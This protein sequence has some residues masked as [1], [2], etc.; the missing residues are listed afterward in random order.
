MEEG[1]KRRR[2]PGCAEHLPPGEQVHLAGQDGEGQAAKDGGSQSFRTLDLCGSLQFASDRQRPDADQPEGALGGSI[3]LRTDISRFSKSE[4]EFYKK[5]GI[6]K[7]AFGLGGR[8][9][10]PRQRCGLLGEVCFKRRRELTDASSISQN[11][12]GPRHLASW[13]QPSRLR[14]SSARP[15]V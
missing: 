7:D 13:T 14:P 2:G 6:L 11:A 3:D 10:R 5:Y 8:G 15:W 9:F 4:Q 1:R 12:R